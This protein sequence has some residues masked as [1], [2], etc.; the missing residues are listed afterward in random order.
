MSDDGFK[1]FIAHV[2]FPP[3]VAC[4]SCGREAVVLKDGLC[5]DC[6]MG[7]EI[8][9]AAPPPAFTDGFTSVYVYNEISGRMVQRLKYNGAKYIAKIFADAIELPKEWKPDALVPVPL[10]YKKLWKRGYNQSEIIAR[11]LSERLDIPLEPDYLM[12]IRDT[13]AQVGLTEAAR[14]SN[15]RFAFS[16]DPAVKDKK[17]LLIDDVCTTGSTLSECAEELKRHGAS[18]VWAAT[19][20]AVRPDTPEEGNK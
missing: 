17:I 1:N 6:H 16:A 15:L 11:K 2:L 20:C 14:K 10:Y 19:V 13:D 5:V 9:N 12:K 8:F 7:I 4:C 18:K 3:N